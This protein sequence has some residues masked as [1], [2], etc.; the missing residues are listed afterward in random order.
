VTLSDNIVSTGIDTVGGFIY[1]GKTLEFDFINNSINNLGRIKKGGAIYLK[2]CNNILI[3]FC[4][5]SKCNRYL[6]INFILF[7]FFFYLFLCFINYYLF[8]Y[9]FMYVFMG[10][11]LF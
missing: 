9:L 5:F 6:F 8:I 11:C 4:N 10:I 1:I 7:Y 2:S 3:S